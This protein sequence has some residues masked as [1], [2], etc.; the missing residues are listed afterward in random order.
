MPRVKE[1]D[2]ATLEQRVYDQ[3]RNR[4]IEG[5][6]RPGTRIPEARLAAELGVSRATVRAALRQLVREGLVVWPARRSPIVRQ[7]TPSEIE[8]IY[9]VRELLE[10]R[11]ASRLATLT[12]SKRTQALRTLKRAFDQL[13]S[14]HSESKT[15]RI[16]EEL[17]FHETMCSLSGNLL[18]LQTWRGLRSHIEM[19][20]HVVP[21]PIF[22]LLDEGGHLEILAALE[23]GNPDEASRI[24]ASHFSGGAELIA[25]YVGVATGST[26]APTGR[27]LTPTLRRAAHS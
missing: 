19:M 23:S 1:L 25:S 11:A 5:L 14:S 12:P 8:E 21:E 16:R 26:G 24:V 13:Q 3:L 27:T 6:L 7:L 22:R 20:L 10:G 15:I 4:M 9:E 17:H 2:S 18:L